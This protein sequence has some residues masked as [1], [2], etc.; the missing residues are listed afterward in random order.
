MRLLPGRVLEDYLFPRVLLRV[1]FLGLVLL[2][3]R[4]AVLIMA[5]F[6]AITLH[7]SLLPLLVM[8][9]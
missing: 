8:V 5:S 2:G 6:P 1:I 4:E 3:M 9:L 7:H